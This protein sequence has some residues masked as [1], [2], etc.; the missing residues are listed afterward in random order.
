MRFPFKPQHPLLDK[1]LYARGRF[2]RLAFAAWLCLVN[3][4]FL[5]IIFVVEF[6]LWL[7]WH[8]RRPVL[9]EYLYIVLMIVLLL[10]YLYYILIIIIRRL[11]DRNH[12]SWFVVLYFVPGLNLIFICY[13]LVSRGNQ[14]LNRYGYPWNMYGWEKILGWCQMVLL[15]L[16]LLG[17]SILLIGF[18][19]NKS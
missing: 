8:D 4:I 1:P 19:F 16:I 7:I 6:C 10:P 17:L 15:L 13:L 3:L 12:R 14:A 5:T 9:I 2:G 18:I 11:H